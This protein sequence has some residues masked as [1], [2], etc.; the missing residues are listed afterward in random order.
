VAALAYVLLP[1]S[2]LLAYLKG[3]TPNVRFH[4]LQAI[5]LG[6]VW[7]LLLYAATWISPAVTQ[8]IFAI[9]LLTWVVMIAT[10]AVG[11][12]L[13]LPVI[14]GWLKGVAEIS[15]LEDQTVAER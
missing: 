12:G 7:P 15:V 13:R 14:A 9:G 11:K 3:T 10:A 1:V 6:T 4:G 5:V 8:A 2:G